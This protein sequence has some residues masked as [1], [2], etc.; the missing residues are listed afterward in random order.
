MNRKEITTQ[1]SVA[2]ENYLN[3]STVSRELKVAQ[4]KFDRVYEH[5]SCVKQSIM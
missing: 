2:L 1:L 3:P 5:Y 4:K